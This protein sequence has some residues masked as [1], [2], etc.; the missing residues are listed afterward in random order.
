[1]IG[2]AITGLSERKDKAPPGMHKSP[3]CCKVGNDCNYEDYFTE[4][5]EWCILR[6]SADLQTRDGRVRNQASFD[7][8]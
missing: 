2:A 7:S 6:E 8:E 5:R 3:R 1:M 4:T